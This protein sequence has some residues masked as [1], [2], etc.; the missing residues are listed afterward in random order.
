[1][2]LIR[3]KLLSLDWSNN[4]SYHSSLCSLATDFFLNAKSE[5]SDHGGRITKLLKRQRQAF[6]QHRFMLRL[7]DVT[8]NVKRTAAGSIH[9]MEQYRKIS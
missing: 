5:D 8:I 7:R 3:Q 1:M 2:K 9:F 4:M 6:T